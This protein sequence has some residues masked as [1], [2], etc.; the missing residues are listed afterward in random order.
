MRKT[1]QST[2][3]YSE[4]W[5][6]IWKQID[7]RWIIWPLTSKIP[8]IKGTFE[9]A[10]CIPGSILLFISLITWD[11]REKTGQLMLYLDNAVWLWYSLMVNVKCFSVSPSQLKRNCLLPNK[12]GYTVTLEVT[13]CD[14]HC[15]HVVNMLYQWN[16]YWAPASMCKGSSTGNRGISLFEFRAVWQSCNLCARCPPWPPPG[17]SAAIHSSYRPQPS[18]FYSPLTTIM[19][20]INNSK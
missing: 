13:T 6:C 3:L 19:H 7:G 10:P 2:T 9:D 16:I 14:L 12:Q 18:V 8:N 11:N 17:D 4:R 20:S 5:Q 1:S 15:K